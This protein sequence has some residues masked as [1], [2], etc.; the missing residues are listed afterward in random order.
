MRISAAVIAV[1][2]IVNAPAE[3]RADVW[4]CGTSPD[5]DRRIAAL[6]ARPRDRAQSAATAIAPPVRRDGAIYLEAN[7]LV[8][9]GFRSFDLLG[10]SLVFSPRDGNRYAVARESLRYVEPVSEPRSLPQGTL[11]ELGFTFSAFGRNVERVY[12]TAFGGI[13][14]DEPQ[15]GVPVGTNEIEA[16]LMPQP[17]IAPLLQ[18][19]LKLF[20]EPRIHVDRT[21][22]SLIVTWR[23]VPEEFG[24]D[25]QAQLHADGSI[26]FSYKS[27]HNVHWGT[28]V[29]TAGS[30]ADALPRRVL[31]GMDVPAGTRPGVNPVLRDMADLR[32]I[33]VL[34]VA[35]SDVWSVRLTLAAPIDASKLQGDQS[36]TYRFI[37]GA[38]FARIIVRRN[39]TTVEP[40]NV[41]GSLPEGV[42]GRV[43]GNTVEIFGLQRA[44][45][46]DEL[47]VA[48]FAAATSVADS[49][50][51]SVSLDAPPARV[52]VDLTAAS[53]SEL[54]LPIVEPF[55]LPALDP[56]AVW[57]QMKA[58]FGFTDEEIDGVAIYQTFFTDL[59][60]FAT[61]YATG[62]NPQVDGI[63][64]PEPGRGSGEPRIPT[65][66]HMNQLN[67]DEN[68]DERMASV[69]MLHEFGHRWLY[70]LEFA[71]A[72]SAKN[73]VLSPQSFHPAAYVDT[74]SAFALYGEDE[75]SVMGGGHFTNIGP[76]RWRAGAQQ[77][78][79]SW[80]DLY[81]MGLAGPDEVSPWFYLAGT[82]L[83]QS[84]FPQDGIEVTAPKHEVSLPQVITALGPRNPPQA[85][86]QRAFRVLFVLVTEPGKEPAAAE[87]AKIEWLRAKMERD[88]SIVTGGRGRV[89]T[90]RP[91]NRRRS[92]R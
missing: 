57:D 40:F 66:L 84:Y 33:D 8:A 71:D 22:S 77:Y 15:G 2:L 46:T 27:M 23:S 62:G 60:L 68:A 11:E 48:T 51:Q 17:L 56:F 90:D 3:M 85:R 81:L 41:Q 35:E 29:L 73:P 63:Q 5:N 42:A 53:G 80:T 1:W 87:V 52:A 34:R 75:S 36:L 12:V 38:E 24:Y 31:S 37:F 25:V 72:Q 44:P 64:P 83:P 76:N 39:G 18:P 4:Q 50:V 61:A 32:R 47:F 14:F 54:P 89:I 20:P 9:P 43:D 86:S 10:N 65:L 82:S 28:P 92:V 21:P 16:L 13:T 45:R 59:V 67:F 78:G 79:F 69:L 74:R 58:A 49:A 91:A 26:V 88:F 6:H 19:S 70:K 7:D 55:V 30:D